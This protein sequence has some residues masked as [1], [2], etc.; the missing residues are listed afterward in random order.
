MW[1][2]LLVYAVTRA[3]DAVFFQVMQAQQV[4]MDPSIPAGHVSY[5]TP[6]APGY[7]VVTGNWD[8]QWYREIAERGY[9]VP[10]PTD[11]AGQ[12]EQNAWAFY[13]VF[14]MLT[15]AI[16]WLTGADFYVAGS[17]LSLVAGA[18][19]LVLLFRLVDRA[20][21]RWP[22][23]VTTVLVSTYVAA[24]VLQT[25]YTEACALLVLVL[26]LTALRSRRYG[27][28]LVALVVLALTRNIVLA[29]APAFIAHAV[30]RWARRD[31]DPFP[32]GQ[33]VWVGV[34]ATS[35]VLLT[36]LWPSVIGLVTGDRDG[37]SKTLAAWGLQATEIKLSTWIDYLYFDYGY[38]GWVVA[39]VLVAAYAAFMVSRHSRA[40]G[41][42]LWGWGGAAPAYQ[43]LVTG[44]GP[45]RLRYFLVA[46]PVALVIA[47]VLD[48]PGLRRVRVPLLVLLGAGGVALQGWW[49][50]NYWI[51][52]AP[53]DNIQ[54][55]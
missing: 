31:A 22:A 47:W 8:G 34:L 54:F 38:R 33:R 32:R 46:F 35:S 55:P 26:V 48:R 42:E 5:P 13:P 7:F 16:M 41:P 21:G 12:V 3:V 18:V 40:W 11:T 20:V 50:W 9:P 17:T 25:T 49:I 1:F 45:S 28:A 27:W 37:Y 43:V 53:D 29:T 6:A 51:I 30:V 24:P 15:R 44:I 14:P 2:P 52:E 23:V 39:G 36:M 4:A 19:A 10:M